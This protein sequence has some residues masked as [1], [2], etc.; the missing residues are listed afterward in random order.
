MA[1]NNFKFGVFAALFSN[2]LFGVLYVYSSW[3]APLSGSDVFAWRML[4][5]VASL[6]IILLASG[7]RRDLT[8]FV[9]GL[10]KDI[11]KWA[12]ML[13]GTFIIASQLWVFMW[14]PVNGEGINVAMGYF[15]FPLTMIIGGWLFCNE[16]VNRWQWLAVGCAGLGVS[17]A[18]WINQSFSWVTLWVCGTYPIY[19]LTRRAMQV[20]S[21]VGLTFDLSL[22]APAAFVYLCLTSGGFDVLSSLNKFW[23][24]IPLLGV[25]SATAMQLNVTASRILPVI[26]F[27]LFSYLEPFLLFILAVVFLDAPL[28]QSDLITYGLIWCGLSIAIVDSVLQLKRKK[29][30][31]FKT[32]PL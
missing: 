32:K 25:I 6:W 18:L 4:G 3:M 28:T 19:Y 1:T 10:G 14:A 26:L 11:K 21:L 29:R 15:L 8:R 5:M 13:L 24:L 20:P 22:I 23:I 16:T 31:A 2:I 27:G 7:S 9:F 12:M 17:Y 30:Q